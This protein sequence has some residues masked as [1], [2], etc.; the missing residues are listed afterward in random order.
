MRW[1]DKHLRYVIVLG[2]IIILIINQKDMTSIY[3][4]IV[5]IPTYHKVTQFK[6]F[7]YCNTDIKYLNPITKKAERRWFWW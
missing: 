7:D 4:K 6:F 1:F 5:G 3:R 2:F